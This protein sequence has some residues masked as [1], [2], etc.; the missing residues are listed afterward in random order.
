MIEKLKNKY[1]KLW[2]N[3]NKCFPVLGEEISIKEKILREKHMNMFLND[4]FSHLKKCPEVEG[5]RANWKNTL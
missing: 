5:P 3:T 1:M 4:L 2:W